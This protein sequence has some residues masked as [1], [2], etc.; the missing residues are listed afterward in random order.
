MKTTSLTIIIP[1]F[2]EEAAISQVVVRLAESFSKT[3]LIVVADGS[4]DSTAQLAVEAGAT[5]ICHRKNQGYGAA[6]RSGIKRS[7]RDYVLFCDAENIGC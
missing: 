3:E 1:A 7:K 5:V 6:L 4:R 2:N